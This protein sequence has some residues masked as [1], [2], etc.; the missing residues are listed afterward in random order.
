MKPENVSLKPSTT[1]ELFKFFLRVKK[2]QIFLLDACHVHTSHKN[3]FKL[4]NLEIK[5]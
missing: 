5:I 4:N 2:T 3:N 1:L